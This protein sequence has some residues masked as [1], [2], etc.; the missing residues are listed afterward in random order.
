MCIYV[1]KYVDVDMYCHDGILFSI[2][3]ENL[4]LVKQHFWGPLLTHT[5]PKHIHTNM[6][7]CLYEY[8]C[9]HVE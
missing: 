2:E 5:T 6:Q 8:A 4:Y 1:C 9:V 7:I 3:I